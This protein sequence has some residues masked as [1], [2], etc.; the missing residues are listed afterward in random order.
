MSLTP[1]QQRAAHAPHSVCVTAGAGTGKTF[2]LAARY[3]YHLQQGYSPLQIVAVTFTNK[4]ATELRSRIRQTVLSQASDRSDWLAELEAAPISTFHSLAGRICREQAQIVGIPPDFTALEEWEGQLWQTEHLAAALDRLPSELYA[5]IPYSLMRAAMLAFLGDRLSAERALNC[6]STQ[7]E[8]AL[9]TFREKELEKLIQETIWQNAW[10]CFHQIIGK[11]GDKIEEARQIVLEAMVAIQA[12]ENIAVKL[13]QIAKVDLRGGSAKS[14]ASKEDLAEVK[15]H[16]KAM[17][18]WVK[19]IEKAGLLTLMMGELDQQIVAILP[20]LKRAFEFVHDYLSQIKQQQRI[21]DFNDLEVYALKALNN[22]KVKDYYSQRWQV[23]L[24]DEFQDTNPIQSEILS[25]LTSLK[26]SPMLKDSKP[27]DALNSPQNSGADGAKILTLVGDEKQSIYGFRRADITIFQSWRSQINYDVALN[28]SFRSHENLINHINQLFQPVLNDLHQNL[29]AHRKIKPHPAPHLEIFAVTPD[30]DLKPKPPV[31]NCRQVEAEH[32]ADIIENLLQKK[33]PIWDKKLEKHRAITPEDIAILSRSWSPLEIYSQ[34]LTNRQI[35]G[36]PIPVV[37][38]K[39]GNLLESREVKDGIALLRFLANARDDLAL[40]AVLRSPFF[41]ISD[42]LLAELAIERSEKSWWQIIQE[43]NL[44]ELI[45]VVTTLKTLLKRRR[46]D[47]P[48]RLL[49]YSDRQTGYTAVIANLPN[50][51][52]RLA[53]WQGFIHLVRQLEMGLA[54]VFTVVRCLQRIQAHQLALPRPPLEARNAVALMTIHGAKGLEW[55]VVIIPDL[56]RAAPNDTSII[57]FDPQVGVSWSLADNEG[58]KQKPALFTLLEQ[59][60]KQREAEEAKRLLYVALTRARDRLI[61]TAPQT[62]GLGLDLLQPGIIGNFE[63]QRIPY[64]PERITAFVPPL[65]PLSETI[66]PLLLNPIHAKGLR[67]PVT[68]LTDYARCPKRFNYAHIQGH[69]GLTTGTT[70]F[71][72]ELGILTHTALEKKIT[73]LDRLQSYQPE[74]P[75]DKIAE[76]LTLADRFRTSSTYATVQTGNWEKPLQFQRSGITFTGKADL[77]GADFVLDIKTDQEFDP[78]EHRFQLWAYAHFLDK[79]Q[80]H[81]AYLR[82]NRLHTFTSQ[83]LANIA[84]EAEDLITQLGDR[85]FDPTPSVANCSICPYSVIC[86]SS[87]S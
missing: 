84:I 51:Q 37:Q 54:D 33:V 55:S 71:A 17:K 57:R 75:T 16:L 80:A 12:G 81:I 24:I 39:G 69:P 4:A 43:S 68:A 35:N 76:A 23:F 28:T 7:W 44:F 19:P 3:L 67:L 60:Q 20:D 79:S 53:D 25:C 49:Q 78:Q 65:P 62:K 13:N 63:V 52:R 36:K 87:V 10:Q 58:E 72:R 66:A 26:N 70:N 30:P 27:L 56:T 22:P 82:H 41:T 38:T 86:E 18:E 59:Q 2:M 50:A 46:S 61:L 45:P 32:I 21:L 11:S 6:D 8:N 1:D 9:K 15:E 29:A 85:R 74:L 5:N 77:V 14:W 73:Q 48:S 83:D 64:E 40:V 47:P 31:E 42:R 34:A